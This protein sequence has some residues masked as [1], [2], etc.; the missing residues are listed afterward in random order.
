MVER[1][2]LRALEQLEAR[3]CPRAL[4]LGAEHALVPDHRDG[5]QHAQARRAALA[6][7]RVDLAHD[8]RGDGARFLVDRRIVEQAAAEREAAPP[9]P[10]LA[11]DVA[12]A[13]GADGA[14]PGDAGRGAVVDGDL[15][16][17]RRLAE[18]ARVLVHDGERLVGG[19]GSRGMAGRERFRQRFA[20]R[21]ERLLG[22]SQLAE[23][24]P[25]ERASTRAQLGRS[26]GREVRQRR[27]DTGERRL[28]AAADLHQ[29]GCRDA[30][31]RR[32][33]LPAA[34]GER[35]GSRKPRGEG[36][37]GAAAQREHAADGVLG[38]GNPLDVSA[39][40]PPVDHLAPGASGGREIA[41]ELGAHGQT[42]QQLEAHRLR[43]AVEIERAFVEDGGVAVGE[44]PEGGR[45]GLGQRS[46]RALDVTRPE[47]LG[48]TRSR[49]RPGLLQQPGDA[50]VERAATRPRDRV[51]DGVA[52]ERVPELEAAGPR[53]DEEPSG[54]RLGQR[55]G[56]ERL[57][58]LDLAALPDHGGL[59]ERVARRQRER[60]GA[61]QDGVQHGLGQR[62]PPG[63]A[64]AVQ[65]DGGRQLLD[66]ERDAVRAFV[67]SVDDLVVELL[68]GHRRGEPLGVLPVEGPQRELEQV[69]F[70]A[71][72]RAQPAEPV[73]V[74]GN[75][76]ACA[77]DEQQRHVVEPA[78][79]LRQE[80]ERG[81]VR[82]VE[83][84]EQDGC[85]PACPGF[86]ECAAERLDERRRARV[87]GRHPELGQQRSQVGR[88]GPA[89]LEEARRSAQAFAQDLRDRRVRL[90]DR[91]SRGTGVGGEAR[92]LDGVRDE[93]RLADAGLSGHE[94]AAAEALA[95]RRRRRPPARLA[96]SPCRSA[97][98]S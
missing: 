56:A 27:L 36:A 2:V 9:L 11:Q 30:G 70:A 6:A 89:G 40:A 46:P 20:H 80:R 25:L 87:L 38:L 35:V 71:H 17:L 12:E 1:C 7:A 43:A 41:R 23:D 53:V 59:L 52:H 3:Q 96:R 18:V 72:V 48:G 34:G 68:T 50:R 28:E 55:I 90:G 31:A 57:H 29:V 95:H 85:R 64:P 44:Q 39:A 81:F 61:Q 76:V 98:G 14:R 78:C 66:V 26:A 33:L 84:V 62:E 24:D 54:Q 45:R 4:H 82:P 47:P 92:L 5:L 73:G 19:G 69:A 67:E 58:M 63:I 16:G 15:V 51:V 77:G 60:L 8:G 74:G 65:R 93:L 86:G 22:L 42:L 88:E 32:V 37:L 97:P 75:L 10:A 13:G 21:R 79:E 49:R 83:V 91:G 94:H